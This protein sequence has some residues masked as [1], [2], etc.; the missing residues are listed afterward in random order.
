MRRA[1][2]PNSSLVWQAAAGVLACLIGLS[3]M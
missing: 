3:I 2:P 1:L